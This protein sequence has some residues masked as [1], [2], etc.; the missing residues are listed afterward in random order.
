M[1]TYCIAMLLVLLACPLVVARERP[2]A[3][4]REN[5]DVTL[6]LRLSVEEFNPDQP[7]GTITCVVRNRSD[8]P[9]ALPAVYDGKTI[10]LE[11]NGLHLWRRDPL[12]K[13]PEPA[14]VTIAP[15]GEHTLFALPLTEILAPQRGKGRNPQWGWD[16][17][18]RPE[19]PL[20]PIHVWRKTGYHP[21]A[22]F[23]AEIATSDGRVVSEPVIL[24]VKGAG[25]EAK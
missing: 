15:G 19:A 21:T 16:W 5:P 8:K 6:T 25:E 13:L 23:R 9:I 22:S 24:K 1:K 14:Q 20:S 10:A 18:R 12:G 4:A 7:A 3:A 17:R 11:G 2:D